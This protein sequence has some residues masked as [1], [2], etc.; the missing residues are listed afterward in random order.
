ME[1]NNDRIYWCIKFSGMTQELLEAVKGLE[2]YLNIMGVE[3]CKGESESE[4]VLKGSS[5][6]FDVACYRII[7]TVEGL[8]H[9]WW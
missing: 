8:I 1:C 9:R 7:H 6:S 5:S 4:I 3:V 2:L